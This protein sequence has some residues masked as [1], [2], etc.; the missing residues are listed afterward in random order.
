MISTTEVK[1]LLI[2]TFDLEEDASNISD[3]TAII[4]SGLELD[5]V[6]ALEI[7]VQIE[8]QFRRK[9]RNEDIKMEAFKNVST[10]T[11][12]INEYQTH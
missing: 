1:N 9:I 10:L 12:F 6:D 7:V 5:S 4:G 8:K 3:D 2:K 11:N